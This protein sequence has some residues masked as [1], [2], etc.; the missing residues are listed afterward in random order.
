[1]GGH[2]GEGSLGGSIRGT[3]DRSFALFRVR[4][5]GGFIGAWVLD[6]R[7]LSDQQFF[8]MVENQMGK[9]MEHERKTGFMDGLVCTVMWETEISVQL[10]SLNSYTLTIISAMHP[11]LCRLRHYMAVSSV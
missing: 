1:M 8:P 4:E 7:S 5:G 3:H 9:N 6:C 10:F 11:L 2:L